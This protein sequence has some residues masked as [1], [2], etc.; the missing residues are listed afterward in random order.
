MSSGTNTNKS[1]H[2][3]LHTRLLYDTRLDAREKTGSIAM[4]NCIKNSVELCVTTLSSLYA[5]HMVMNVF[6]IGVRLGWYPGIM[7][8]QGI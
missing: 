5:V 4:L 1:H 3:Y 6:T 7:V 8:Y 2:L